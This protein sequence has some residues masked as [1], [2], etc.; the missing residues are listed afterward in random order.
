MLAYCTSLLHLEAR[1]R[2]F[3]FTL[4]RKVKFKVFSKQL[5][6]A[7]V[8]GISFLTYVTG[9]TNS[10]KTIGYQNCGGGE[11]N[12]LDQNHFKHE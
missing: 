2:I 11:V 9:T 3:V 8:V 7:S 10:R 6:E 4:G 5:N 1:L 12:D